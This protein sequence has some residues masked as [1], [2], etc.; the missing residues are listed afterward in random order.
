MYLSSPFWIN[1]DIPHIFLVMS[2]ISIFSPFPFMSNMA[3]A[4]FDPFSRP[5]IIFPHASSVCISVSVCVINLYRAVC[6]RGGNDGH[7][8]TV[9]RV[10]RVVKVRLHPPWHGCERHTHTHT[11]VTLCEC[12]LRTNYW[13][14]VS[15]CVLDKQGVLAWTLAANK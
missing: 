8:T 5:N 11:C 3:F 6:G 12:V 4:Q 13:T 15:V 9:P 10:K 7:L 1:N 14:C 2:Y